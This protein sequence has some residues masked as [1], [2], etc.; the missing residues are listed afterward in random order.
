MT[1][2]YLYGVGDD[3][4]V[5]RTEP[6][7]HGDWRRFTTGT[8]VNEILF[9]G[10]TMYGAGYSDYA[11]YQTSVISGGSWTKVVDALSKEVTSLAYSNGYLFGVIYYEVWRTKPHGEWKK[12]IGCCVERIIIVGDIIYGTA[13]QATGDKPEG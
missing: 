10:D 5:W 1:V 8:K 7:M 6:G 12:F 3:H 2:N 11:V 9:H 4:H 13:Q